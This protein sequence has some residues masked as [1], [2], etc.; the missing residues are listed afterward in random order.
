MSDIV[1][2][3]PNVPAV[4]VG[5]GHIVHPS[6]ATMAGESAYAHALRLALGARSHLAI[7]HVAHPDVG[8]D[9]DWAAFP[10]VRATLA[11][12]G[13]LDADAAPSEV[14]D[15]LG[16]RI[17]KIEVADKDPARGLDRY[18]ADRPC[19]LLVLATQARQGLD[20]LMNGSIAE[21][22]ARSSRMP[23]LLLPVGAD[24]FVDTAT[25]TSRL[26]NIL[27]PVDAA[28]APLDAIELALAIADILEDGTALLHLL[29][30]GD[31]GD[32]PTLAMEPRLD[33][34]V[35]RLTAAGPVVQAILQTADSTGA[36]L[37]AMATHGHDSIL[38]SLRGS[39]TEQVLQ[40]APCPV[41]AVPV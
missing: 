41:L 18:L 34:R 32:A 28:T 4:P 33:R 31:P 36:D 23:A 15:R 27:V 19:S 17:S 7:V 37:I 20:R 6:D 21:A 12:W 14:A 11:R 39:T 38:D 10:G 8:E 35:Q 30:V 13:L 29:H 25:G 16:V 1:P 26:R 2:F 22:V 5:L 9:A 24:G 40:A 3:L